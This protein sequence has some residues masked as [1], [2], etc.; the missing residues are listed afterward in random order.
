MQLSEF[1]S[2]SLPKNDWLL[3]ARIMIYS[4]LISFYFTGSR[5]GGGHHYHR[6][7]FGAAAGNGI[8]G[9]GGPGSSVSSGGRHHHHHHRG[10]YGTGGGG[11]SVYEAPSSMMSSDLESTSFFESDG[12]SSR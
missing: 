4:I 9:G 11:S 5:Y 8:Y 2:S 7:H 6:H 10:I 1:I 3:Q 12:E